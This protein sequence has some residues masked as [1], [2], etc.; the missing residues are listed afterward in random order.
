MSDTDQIDDPV[1]VRFFMRDARKYRPRGREWG[2]AEGVL[3]SRFAGRDVMRWWDEKEPGL[4]CAENIRL[5]HS[6]NSKWTVV[7]M[8]VSRRELEREQGPYEIIDP[9]SGTPEQD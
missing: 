3:T 5:P 1:T 6:P 2:A 4:P 7:E 9:P 8:V